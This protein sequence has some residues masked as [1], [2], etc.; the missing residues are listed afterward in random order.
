MVATWF[1]HTDVG[2]AQLYRTITRHLVEDGSWVHLRYLRGVGTPFFDHLPTAFWPFAFVWRNFGEGALI[3]LCALLSLLTVGVAGE[4]ARRLA[5]PWAGIAAML[6]LATTEKFF[7]QTSYPTLDP[8]LL[9]LASL[10]ALFFLTGPLNPRA[11]FLTFLCAA[12]ATAV[13]GPFGCVPLFGAIVGRAVVEKSWRT[14]FAGAAVGLLAVLPVGL[15]LWTHDDWWHGYVGTQL[16]PSL[17]GARTDGRMNHWYAARSIAGRFWPWFFLAVP[18]AVIALQWPKR[19]FTWLSPDEASSPRY[20][21]AAKLLGS[22][23]LAMTAALSVPSRQ[24]WHH[25]LVTYPLLSAFC[26]VAIAPRLT[27]WLTSPLAQQRGLLGLSMLCVLCIAAS[28]GGLDKVLMAPPCVLA[29]DLAPALNR[30]SPGTSVLVPVADWDILSCL[31]AERRLE[32][33]LVQSLDEGSLD[34][35]WALVPEREWHHPAQ[36]RQVAS[37]RGWVLAQRAQPPP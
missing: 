23:C 18:A 15:F 26:A 25:T 6:I 29:T 14:L 35:K 31:A 37:G 11:L 19:F 2:N 27:Q 3:P 7:F 32:P 21:H 34:V 22:A 4:I 17:T 8:V 1:R 33:W 16:F 13:K 24:I 28:V 5:G 12:A 10:A 9:P 30:L 20:T 36:W